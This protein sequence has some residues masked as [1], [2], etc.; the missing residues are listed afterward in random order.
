MGKMLREA[1]VAL[2]ILGKIRFFLFDF[3]GVFTSGRRGEWF[4]QRDSMG[5][6]MLRLGCYLRQGRILE[7]GIVT[8]EKN[9]VVAEFA[10]SQRLNY[11]FFGIR[12]KKLVRKYLRE[13]M[14]VGG[15]DMAVVFDDVNDLPLVEGAKWRVLVGQPGS[16]IFTN[17]MRE[18]GKYDYLTENCGGRGAV[19]EVCEQVLDSG[20]VL[21]D[22]IDH[23]SKF[24]EVY[25]KYWRARNSIVP[26]FYRQEGG[27][28][29]K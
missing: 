25:R 5:L 23:R 20:G 18:G 16:V 14:Q 13:E 1:K 12:D 24:S 27:G 8:G 22:C 21:S 28:L 6:N 4:N 9:E 17:K 19:R 2:D 11:V 3:D 15:K 29:V 26:V 7:M 10:R